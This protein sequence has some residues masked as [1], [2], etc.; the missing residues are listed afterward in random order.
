MRSIL[1]VFL[2][3]VLIGCATTKNQE[4]TS[5]TGKPILLGK[6]DRSGMEKAPY[7]EW[8]NATYSGY[9]LDKTTLDKTDLKGV[10]IKLF[11]GTWCGDS[12]EQVPRFYKMLDYKKYPV[13]KMTVIALDNHPDRRKTS[14]GGEE[15]GWNIEYVPTFIVLKDGKEMG[16]IVEYPKASLEK[17]LA[18]IVAKK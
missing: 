15:K 3:M 12:Q 9:E 8:F 7:N 18:A 1:F 5:H 16:R 6:V 17:D 13:K 4:V 2:A 14:P 11:L 10:E